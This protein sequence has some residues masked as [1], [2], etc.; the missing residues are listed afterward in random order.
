MEKMQTTNI[1]T[2]LKVICKLET[3]SVK[4]CNGTLQ[5]QNNKKNISTSYNKLLLLK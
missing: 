4:H 3:F 5:A 1:I 2:L